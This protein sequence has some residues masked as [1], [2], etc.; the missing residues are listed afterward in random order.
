MKI[1]YVAKGIDVNENIKNFA[2]KKAQEN[3]QT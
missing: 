3:W 2:E 1:H